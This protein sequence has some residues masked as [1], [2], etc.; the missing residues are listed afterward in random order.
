MI[1]LISALQILHTD[2]V[3]FDIPTILS[4]S[5]QY[6]RL[7]FDNFQKFIMK[8]YLIHID[9][10]LC[11]ISVSLSLK[12]DFVKDVTRPEFYFFL[13]IS[14]TNI[15]FIQLQAFGVFN[16]SKHQTLLLF[17]NPNPHFSL[18]SQISTAAFSL[19]EEKGHSAN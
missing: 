6:V 15:Q 2:L 13:M 12:K 8:L 11:S 14:H 18:G 4:F 3:N 9:Y 5:S 17:L 10:C 16:T 19:S 7:L 1:S